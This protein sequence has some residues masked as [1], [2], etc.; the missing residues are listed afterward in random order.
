MIGI[1]RCGITDNLPPQR[2][3]RESGDLRFQSVPGKQRLP[4]QQD[5]K[6]PALQLTERHILR[7]DEAV[8]VIAYR[9]YGIHTA[10][11]IAALPGPVPVEQMLGQLGNTVHTGARLPERLFLCHSFHCMHERQIPAWIIGT[12]QQLID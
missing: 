5:I 10:R 7:Q 12:G 9:R 8:I 6:Q 3:F 1:M 2:G 4:A 11:L